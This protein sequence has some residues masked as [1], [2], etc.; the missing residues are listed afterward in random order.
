MPTTQNISLADTHAHLDMRRFDADRD[1]VIARAQAAGLNAII[2]VGIDPVSSRRAV[3][4]S[5]RHQV[6]WAAVGIHPQDSKQAPLTDINVIT[7]LAQNEK[8]IAIGE[9]GLDYYRDYAPRE[10]QIK[11]F[12]QQLE[13]AGDLRKPVI[14]HCRQA[15]NA[16]LAMLQEWVERGG[17]PSSC[18]V[19]VI[20]CFNGT[21]E[22]AQAY[23]NMGFYLGL[24]AYIGYPSSQTMHETI[25]QLPLDRLLIETDCPFLPPQS[26]RGERNEP[27]YVAETAKKLAEIKGISLETIAAQ[28]YANTTK[29]FNLPRRQ[30]PVT[31]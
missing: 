13:L 18:G 19:G 7:E 9:I 21:F 11:V 1:E 14:I 28:V 22:T 2:T 10:Q 25:R 12:R 27:A 20:H 24:G 26:K 30:T 15:E 3:E 4:L 8:V 23:L 31:S 17:L 6:V 5:H 16:V 29:L